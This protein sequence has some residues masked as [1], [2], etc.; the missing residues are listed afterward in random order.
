MLE[1]AEELRAEEELQA[2]V[3]QPVQESGEPAPSSGVAAPSSGYIALGAVV[4]QE[5]VLRPADREEG[6]SASYSRVEG[7]SASY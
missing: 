7:A 6:A 5:L 2:A 1:A 3:A 4:G